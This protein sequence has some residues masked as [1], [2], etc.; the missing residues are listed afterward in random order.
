MKSNIISMLYNLTSLLAYTFIIQSILMTTKTKEDN[1][2]ISLLY[3]DI[4]FPAIS[5]DFKAH[6]IWIFLLTGD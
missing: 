2:L 1:G 4:L 5:L 6:T 3:V